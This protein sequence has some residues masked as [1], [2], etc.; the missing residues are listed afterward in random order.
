MGEVYRAFDLRL[1]RPVALKLLA[2]GLSDD[3]R[4]R[5]RL[6][7]ESRLAAALDHPNVVPVYEAGGD[8]GRLFIAM[9]Y[10]EGSDLRALLR[11]PG[12]LEPER[13][14]RI[15]A[16]L[17]DALDSA[18]ARGLVHRDVK[19]SNVLVD[20]P[21]GREHP[22]LAD[23]GLTQSAAHRGPADGG[24]MGTID[25]VAPEQVRGDDVDGRADQYA[26][27]CL[28]FE[29]LT[30]TLPYQHKSELE[31][32][33]AHWEE[34]PPAA[35]S[36]RADL[37]REVDDVLAKGMAKEPSERYPTCTELVEAVRAALGLEDAQR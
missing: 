8:A 16:P 34:P 4:F 6:L 3:E 9:R 14:V 32:I 26:L 5:E 1:E 29:C 36:R 21:G 35:S 25:Y 18:H 15:A 30:G 2:A 28:I 10:V 19:P 17:A 13:V 23:F 20:D 33:F 22:Y 24:L 11:R 37:P 7:R 12:R 27:T 31:T